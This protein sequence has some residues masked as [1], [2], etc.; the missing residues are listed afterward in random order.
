MAD[1][2]YLT[3]PEVEIDPEVAVDLWPLSDKGRARAVLLAGSGVLAGVRQIVSSAETKA[4]DTAAPLAAALGLTVITRP[5][6]HEN[7]RSAAGFLPPAEFE[8]VADAFFAEPDLSVRGWETAR[9]A[10]TRIVGETLTVLRDAPPGD[11]LLVGHGA[12]GTLLMCH[13]AGWP[14]DRR[15][16]QAAGGGCLFRA[17]RSSLR[18]RHGWQRIEALVA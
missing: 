15:H 18:L 12:V 11:L 2:W 10:Q 6:M 17:E 1:L 16:D 14:I 7:D 13:I 4:Q 3:H 5:L 8:T 9:A